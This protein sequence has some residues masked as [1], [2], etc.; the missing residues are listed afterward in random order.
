VST[1]PAKRQF[2]QSLTR[3]RA[4]NYKTLIS[5]IALQVV[6]IPLAFLISNPEKVQRQD[7]SEI[8]LSD[9][10]STKEQ[11]RLLWQTCSSRKVGVLLPVFFVRPSAGPATLS[12]LIV[13]TLLQSSW[14]V[15]PETGPSQVCLIQ[16]TR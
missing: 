16:L 3:P 1:R 11:I 14:F 15:R 4:V 10:T 13:S 12:L 6:A 7:R 8:P 5:F 9:K 2:E